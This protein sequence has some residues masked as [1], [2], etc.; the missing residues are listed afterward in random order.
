M[1][2]VDMLFLEVDLAVGGMEQRKIHMLAR[3]NL[4]RLGYPA[5]VCIHTPLLHGTDGSEKMS[6]SKENFIA[7]DDKPE[8]IRNKVKKCYCPPG[9]LEGNPVL[10]MAQHFIFTDQKTILIKRP[11]KF[12]G[13]LNLNQTELEQMY[14]SGE[15]HPLDLKNAVAN[16][17]VEI[18]EPV[19][20]YMDNL[21]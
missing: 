19:R 6:S 17:L 10:E 5:P 1:Q 9:E 16:H 21:K 7:I 12:G 8:V 18:L 4:P 15:L 13:D 14:S 20:S 11:E 3:D 2:V